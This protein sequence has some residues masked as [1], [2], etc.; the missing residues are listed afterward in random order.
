MNKFA[1][2]GIDT[3]SSI[4]LDSLR[5]I[6]A[7]TVVFVHTQAQLFPA[8][9]H[10]SS[11]PVDVAH[12]AVVVFFVLSGFVIAHTTASNN[13]GARQYALARLSRL[14][15][16]V[17]PALF[18]TA[19]IESV[20]KYARYDLYEIYSRGVSWPRYLMAGSFLSEIWFFS[21]A[22]PMNGPLWSLSF[23][24]WYYVIFGL[25]FYRNKGSRSFILPVAACFIAGPKIVLMMP[26]W[27]AGFAAYSLPKPGIDPKLRWAMVLLFLTLTMALI[28]CLAPYPY[29]IRTTQFS[30]AGGFVTDWIIGLSVAL[31]LWMLPLADRLMQQAGWINV[32]RKIAD[33]TFPIY[34][35]HFPLLILW[36]TLFN[37]NIEHS[38]Q[39]WQAL[40]GIC[41]VS[42][43]L[44]IIIEKQRFAW[45]YFFKWL[46]SNIKLKSFHFYII[47]ILPKKII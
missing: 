42:A 11:P 36:R 41:L 22:P 18:L 25:W 47:K 43:I 26:I 20:V 12:D 6:S 28:M 9:I 4:Y 35:L 3:G 14:Y 29:K 45:I 46:I 32:F 7:L 13:R 38:W 19:I 30:Y 23:E 39:L 34:V 16:V 40:V 33:L 2:R 21:A 24:F 37:Y 5:L 44:G 8:R 27:M 1:P 31:G 10:L 15:S 17:I